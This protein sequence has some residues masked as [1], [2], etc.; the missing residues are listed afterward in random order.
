MHVSGTDSDVQRKALG[1]LAV[2]AVLVFI[3]VSATMNWRFGYSLGK[4]D[5]DGQVYGSASVAAD[6]LKAIVPFFLFAALKER[7]MFQAIAALLV[8]A[9]VTAYSMTSALGHASLNRVTTSSQRTADATA[10]KDLRADLK[11]TQDALSWLPPHRGESTVLSDIL[12]KKAQKFWNDTNACT[13]TDN[14]GA[15]LFCQDYHKLNA[16]LGSA[17]DQIKYD[18]RIA[19]IEEKIKGLDKVSAGGES[20]ADPQAASISHILKALGATW[21]GIGETQTG[22]SLF[23]AILIEVCSNFGLYMAVGYLRNGGRGFIDLKPETTPGTSNAAVPAVALASPPAVLALAGAPSGSPAGPALSAQLPVPQQSAAAEAKSE[24]IPAPDGSPKSPPKAADSRPI[25][26]F[27]GRPIPG[28]EPELRSFGF[29]V[30]GRPP[31][32]ARSKLPV[33]EEADQF[34][35]A[36]RAYGMAD[37]PIWKNDIPKLYRQYAI[38][39]HR[40]MVEEAAL[41]EVMQRMRSKGV[42]YANMRYDEAKPDNKRLS[43]R[44]AGKQYPKPKASSNDNAAPKEVGPEEKRPFASSAAA[45][46]DA[47]KPFLRIVPRAPAYIAAHEQWLIAESRR[48]KAECNGCRSRKQRGSRVHKLGRAA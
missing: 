35:R 25:N 26:I 43:Y 4:T 44:I 46:P 34:C 39:N 38:A 40:E 29:P 33:K 30:D 15:R 1:G 28:S 41:L 45:A 14:K 27:L 20:A 2:L 17:R 5:F 23:V 3:G 42:E 9:I 7:Q 16:E 18:A 48:P 6:L 37:V 12:G 36:L 24:P 21:M 13:D 19:E 31:G 11:R 22:L 32:P 47:T 8:W 10:Y